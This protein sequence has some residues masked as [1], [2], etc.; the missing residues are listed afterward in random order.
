MKTIDAKTAKLLADYPKNSE[1]RPGLVPACVYKAILQA[2]L[3][4]EYSVQVGS[5]TV[6]QCVKLHSE[7][8]V[9]TKPY[10]KLFPGCTITW[11]E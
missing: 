8:F 9:I 6:D 1:A 10:S 4:H 2:A 3:Q 11:K 7:G 5:L